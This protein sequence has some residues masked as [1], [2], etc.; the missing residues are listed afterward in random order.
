MEPWGNLEVVVERVVAPKDTILNSIVT[1]AHI[2]G[3][4]PTP[5]SFKFIIPRGVE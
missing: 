3:S 5:M 4:K 2:S 1:R